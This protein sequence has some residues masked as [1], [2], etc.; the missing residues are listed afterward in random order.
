MKI[1]PETYL[2]GGKYRIIRSLGQGG[3]GITYEAEQVALRRRVAIK[4]FFM[5]DYCNRDESTVFVSVPTEN[6]RDL[7]D[8]YKQ[9]FVKE[10]QMI[11]SL[12]HPHI[13]SIYDVFEENGTAYYVMEYLNGGSLVDVVRQRGPLPEKDALGYVSQI[14]DALSYIHERNIL[15]LDIKP[16]NVLLNDAGEAVLI[17]F[18]ISKHYDESGGQTSTTPVGISKGY[19]PMEQYQ[20]GNVN[21][22]SPATDI[23]SLGATLYYLI[24]GE[25]PPEAAAIYED[26]LPNI[27]V[28]SSQQSLWAIKAAMEPKRKDRPQSVNSF[29]SLLNWGGQESVSNEKDTRSRARKVGP[30]AIASDDEKTIIQEQKSS[31]N[32]EEQAAGKGKGD[33]ARKSKRS[34]VWLSI[35]ALLFVI[36]SLFLVLG[37]K[38]NPAPRTGDSILIEGAH[39]YHISF[40]S[41]GGQKEYQ[42]KKSF[43]EDWTYTQMPDWCTIHIGPTSFTVICNNNATGKKRSAVI[44]FLK[45]GTQIPLATLTLDQSAGG[46]TEMLATG[47]SM[48][49]THY[50]E[51]KVGETIHLEYSISPA[52]A[53]NHKVSW[54]S[55]SPSVATVGSNGIIKAKGN[56]KTTIIAK[57]DGVS[58]KCVL[59][60]C[61]KTDAQKTDSNAASSISSGSSISNNSIASSNSTSSSSPTSSGKEM[62]ISRSELTLSVGQSYTLY[63]YNYGSSLSWESV[64]PKVATVSWNGKV[65]AVGPGST[66]I[67]A[68]GNI[69]KCCSLTVTENENDRTNPSS[70]TSSPSSS[71]SSGASRTIYSKEVTIKVG[72]KIVAQLPEG[73]IDRWE[74]D[75]YSGNYLRNSGNGSI[76]AKKTGYTTVWGYIEGHPKLF[77]L[78]IVDSNANVPPSRPP[79]QVTTKEFTMYVGDQITAK[80]SEGAITKWEIGN[81]N[82]K[83]LSVYGDVLQAREAGSVTVWGYVGN[84]PKRFKI[85]IKAR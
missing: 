33:D 48:R 42:L 55:S 21:S 65:T 10:A 85:T 72:E 8:S 78:T 79:Y 1:K 71:Y 56:G 14:G 70:S 11:A 28:R 53:K 45:I 47:I 64:N 58:A 13:V 12:R 54:S 80:I 74:I 38:S 27:S 6:N 46:Q 82:K 30:K 40:E 83:Y 32:T 73:K 36:I 61:I 81:N 52:A 62:T 49:A 37:N 76:T 24:T 29:L 39:S 35:V 4:E 22:F 9:K 5:R 16:S 3:F 67:W 34:L 44:S 26:G 57:V 17:D 31:K 69:Y 23:Y 75:N 63:A 41:G 77:K 66:F 84:S 7:V 18:G 20:Q 19:A 25:T 59:E 51:V 50:V 15:H 43:E 60:V 2:Q 68:K